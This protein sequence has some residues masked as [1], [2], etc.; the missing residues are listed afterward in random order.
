MYSKLNRPQN[1]VCFIHITS[2]QAYLFTN[3][4]KVHYKPTKTSV[5][6]TYKNNKHIDSDLKK[7]SK[8]GTEERHKVAT[9]TNCDSSLVFY[10]LRVAAPPSDSPVRCDVLVDVELFSYFV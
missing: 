2:K 6:A 3:K 1:N 10:G 9:G 8:N 5:L 7:T 4:H